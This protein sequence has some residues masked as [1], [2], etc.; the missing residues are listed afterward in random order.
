ML[1]YISLALN[2]VQREFDDHQWILTLTHRLPACPPICLTGLIPSVLSALPAERA[3][4]PTPPAAALGHFLPN[5]VPR[6]ALPP[7][8]LSGRA[9]CT[10]GDHSAQNTHA[11]FLWWFVLKPFLPKMTWWWDGPAKIRTGRRL[12]SLSQSF[13]I[14]GW[15]FLLWLPVRVLSCPVQQSL[16]S[17]PVFSG[18][19]FFLSQS[20]KLYIFNIS[21]R[22]WGFLT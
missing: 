1:F 12:R 8:W 15:C 11:G 6:P 22:L 18:A 13:L 3:A 5:H 7:L 20:H 4:P 19:H 9:F 10:H 17:W 14:W 16:S 21:Q 2:C